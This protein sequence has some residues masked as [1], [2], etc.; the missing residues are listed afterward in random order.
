MTYQCAGIDFIELHEDFIPGVTRGIITN[1]IAV[2]R[3]KRPID[4]NQYVQPICLPERRPTVNS[5]T[6]ATGWGITK[7]K[8][9]IFI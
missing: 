4:F 5:V 7:S 2:I 6:W 3:L 1:D 8:H 9:S